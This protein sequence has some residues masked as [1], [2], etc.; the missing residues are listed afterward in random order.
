MIMDD[1]IDKKSKQRHLKQKNVQTFYKSKNP[2]KRNVS[3][4]SS[5]TV[6]NIYNKKKCFKS[7]YYNDFWR[8]KWLWR[9]LT[10]EN[11]ALPSQK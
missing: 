3:Q 10:S 4:K 5:T 6:L 8:I 1:Y 2:E 11:S 7:A 9:L